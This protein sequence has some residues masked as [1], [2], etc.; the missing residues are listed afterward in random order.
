[1]KK[2]QAPELLAKRIPSQSS[3]MWVFRLH[4]YTHLFS[5]SHCCRVNGYLFLPCFYWETLTVYPHLSFQLVLW[6]FTVWNG[7]TWYVYLCPWYHF[8]S[9]LQSKESVPLKW[10]PSL[11]RGSPIFRN[12]SQWTVAV[13]STGEK[14]EKTSQLLQHAVCINGTHW[15]LCYYN[16]SANI[17]KSSD[18]FF[19]P[20]YP[21]ILHH[22][23]LLPVEG[24]G[25]TVSGWGEPQAYVSGEKCL[26][27]SPQGADD[28]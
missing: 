12:P 13:S 11:S 20:S 1:M 21:Q 28:C 24:S 8:L 23:G 18:S 19:S 7:D 2:W 6:H 15:S 22:Q 3:D 14:P 27:Q 17:K 9:V 4:L 16:T 10:P 26:R 5:L 25:S